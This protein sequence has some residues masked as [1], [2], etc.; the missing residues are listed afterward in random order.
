MQVVS[1]TAKQ[2]AKQQEELAT[3]PVPP[4]KYQGVVLCAGVR[5]KV[6]V[7]FALSIM[8]SIC[9]GG[10]CCGGGG[11]YLQC[12]AVPSSAEQPAEQQQKP[13]TEPA[14]PAKYQRHMRDV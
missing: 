5:I 14:P 13:A 7:W 11:G 2:P 3:E 8:N 4:A 10:D 9:F 1:A 12:R 6:L